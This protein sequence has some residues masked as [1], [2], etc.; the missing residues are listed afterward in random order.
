MRGRI[1][2]VLNSIADDFGVKV[3]EDKGFIESHFYIKGELAPM[4]EALQ[5]LKSIFPG[6]VR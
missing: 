5:T 3:Y 1:R 4:V 2:G 6:S